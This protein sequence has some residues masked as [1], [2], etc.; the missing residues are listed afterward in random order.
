MV[1]ADILR[2]VRPADQLEGAVAVAGESEEV[3]DGSDGLEH[4]GA[5]FVGADE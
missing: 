2:L 4:L 5:L 3:F 1:L